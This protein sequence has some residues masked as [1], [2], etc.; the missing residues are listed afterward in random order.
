[1]FVAV[2]KHG[3]LCGLCILS[4]RVACNAELARDRTKRKAA[5]FRL[6][7]CLPV[8]THPRGWLSA[9][10]RFG[11]SWRLVSIRLESDRDVSNWEFCLRRAANCAIYCVVEV[12]VGCPLFFTAQFASISHPL[13]VSFTILASAV[14]SLEC[15]GIDRFHGAVPLPY[16]VRNYKYGRRLGE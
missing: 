9:R 1:M 8:G 5:A 10:N 3:R 13:L 16:V 15:E 2:A 12:G 14:L 6:L 7:D 4:Y 11:R